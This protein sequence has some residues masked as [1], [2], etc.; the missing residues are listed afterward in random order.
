M[1]LINLIKKVIFVTM[2]KKQ[3]GHII[4]YRS[5]TNLISNSIDLKFVVTFFIFLGSFL[6][7][8]AQNETLDLDYNPS[9]GVITHDS[10]KSAHF[11]IKE[12]IIKGTKITKDK[13]IYREIEYEFGD[14]LLARTIN[15]QLLWVKNRIFNTTLFLWVDIELSGDDPI[16]KTLY[17]TVKERHYFIPMPT[18]GLIDRNFNEWWQDRNHDLKRLYFGVNLKM[19]NLWGLNHTL[20]AT[21]YTGFNTKIETNY[22]IPYINKNLKTGLIINTLAEFNSLLA[23]QTFEHKLSYLEFDG[24]I[25][26]RKYMVGLLFTRRNKFYIQHQLG[27]YFQYTSIADT[28]AKL[29]PEFFLEGAT[30][31]RSVGMKYNFIRDRRDY[32]NYPL[33]GNFLKIEADY[34]YLN[35]IKNLHVTSLRTEYT[36][37]IPI[38][39]RFYF[40]AGFKGKMSSPT[41]QPYFS[42]RGLGYNKEWVSGYERYVIDGQA[43]GLFKTNTKWKM[44]SIKRTVK[45]V[46]HRKFKTIPISMY[47]KVYADAGYVIDKTYN[48]FNT[49]L[50][51]RLLAGGGAGFDI[52][53]YYDLVIRLE[54]SINQLGQTGFYLHMKASL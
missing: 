12:I 5:L 15:K 18:G 42:Q 27:P 48:P 19:R 37:Y 40:S 28:I 20:K 23:Y 21:A 49:T 44:F 1:S 3:L 10:I 4:F 7:N 47:F 31:Q 22:I 53:T 25:G 30:Y 29:N 43:H 32:I 13:I 36:Q 26:R 11:I 8:Y 39:K 45:F 34:Q 24:S 54:Y 6:P 2:F 38:S 17:I 41:H 52:V 33:K 16:N 50:S 14:T 51:N 35:S 9:T 46:P